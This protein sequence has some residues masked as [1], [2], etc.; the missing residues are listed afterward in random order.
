MSQDQDKK[1]RRRPIEI[2]FPID[3]VNEIAEKEAH[4][5]RYYRPVYTMHKWWA[6]RLGS[7]FRTMLLYALADEELS[8]DSER[9]STLEDQNGL[10]KVDWENPDALWEYYLEDID[11]DGKTMLVPPP[12]NGSRIVFPSKSMSSR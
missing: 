7:V 6:R 3:Q 10:P 12:M 4:A 8:V 1:S 9:Q 2:S 5:K 11:F